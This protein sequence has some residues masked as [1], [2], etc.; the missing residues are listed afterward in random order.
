MKF[1]NGWQ[2][3]H[4]SK[5]NYGHS[6]TVAWKSLLHGIGSERFDGN[7]LQ[8]SVQVSNQHTKKVSCDKQ[9]VLFVN[10]NLGYSW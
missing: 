4:Q 7:F 3:D 8:T 10:E 1:W 2:S 9:S 5:A 6:T